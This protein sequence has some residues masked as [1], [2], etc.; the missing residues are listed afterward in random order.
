MSVTAPQ[1]RWIT[2]P[3]PNPLA[4]TRLFCFP[5]AGAG[6]GVFHSWRS[7]LDG[8][9]LDLC[10]VQLPGRETRFRETPITAM[11][12]LVGHICD[13]IAPYFDLPFSLFGHS[14][15]T[16]ISFEVTR[17]LARRGQRAPQWLLMSGACP[18]HRRP[19]ESLHTLPTDEFLDALAQRYQA[20]PREVLADKDLLDV[21]VPILRADFELLER[22][23]YRPGEPL[24]V[25]IA[26]FGGRQ[27]RAVPPFEL[28]RWTDLTAYPSAFRTTFFEGDHFYLNHQRRHLVAA[29]AR[30]LT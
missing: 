13:S 9:D 4:R 15:G 11:D 7:L 1:T 10:C 28:Q 6:A 25:N 24:S 23:R 14:M 8:N 26:V 21:I 29:V 3:K 27:D 2:G 5:Y 30:I 16:L 12:D 20:L 17:E 18:P 22:Y 19:V